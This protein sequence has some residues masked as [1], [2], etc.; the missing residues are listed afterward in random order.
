MDLREVRLVQ[1]VVK[2]A[3]V[4]KDNEGVGSIDSKIA[5]N[6]VMELPPVVA[7]LG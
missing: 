1:L 3:N 4:P 2:W 5:P 7:E 6:V